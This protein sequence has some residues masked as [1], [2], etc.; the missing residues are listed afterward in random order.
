MQLVE[1]TDQARWDE[2]VS[3]H[4]SGHPL[5]LWAWGELKRA[6]GW[7][8]YRVAIEKNGELI[9]GAQIL[10]L[11]IPGL[12]RRMAYV[13]RGPIA[14]PQTKE[15]ADLL[16]ELAT[17]CRSQRALFLTV[18]PAW[19]EYK[20]DK[21]WLR[22]RQ[23]VFLAESYLLDLTSN[24]D[25]LFAN[26]RST[27]RNLVRAG[28]RQGLEIITDINHEHLADF[29]RIYK[30]TAKR[31]KFKL[32]DLD[33]YKK[34]ANNFGKNSCL[35]FASVDGKLEAFSWVVWSGKTAIELYGGSTSV[36]AK[37]NAN[38]LLKW[39]MLQTMKALGIESYDFNGRLNDGISKFKAGFGSRE[40]TFVGSYDYPFHRGRYTLWHSILPVAKSVR[41][42][43]SLRTRATRA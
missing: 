7:L 5:Q 1:I 8:P 10:M 38:Y 16:T 12:R 19:E 22:S 39:R 41:R 40:V 6:G 35:M 21:R 20:F 14:N 26:M 2:F 18:E 30:E 28:E 31:G 3:N 11:P 25:T 37:A 4:P 15:S 9:S 34:L 32:H 33:Y 17:F 13:P 24:E 43:V 29:W 36:G 27:M 23:H 42:R